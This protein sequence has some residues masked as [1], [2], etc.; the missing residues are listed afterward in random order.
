MNHDAEIERYLQGRM[1]H[2]ERAAFEVRF[3]EDAELF[4]RVQLL[5]AFR[6]G[7]QQ[8][9]AALTAASAVLPFRAWLRQPLSLAASVLVTALGVAAFYGQM[10]QHVP[11]VLPVQTLVML[12]T[13]R[14][15]AAANITGAGPYLLQIDAGPNADAMNY[16][17]TLRSDDGAVVLNADGLNADANGWVR[18]MYTQALSGSYVATLSWQDEAGQRREQQYPLVVADP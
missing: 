6:E 4:E 5:D 14:G 15:G 3:M 9:Q 18:V 16:T 2:A 17:V 13:L 7:I 1:T 10:E 12:E 8:E 11:G